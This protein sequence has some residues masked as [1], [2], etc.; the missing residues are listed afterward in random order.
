LKT[1][2]VRKSNRTIK[3]ISVYLLLIFIVSSIIS[4][5]Q[6]HR[7][8]VN[9][10]EICVFAKQF[11]TDGY[12]IKIGKKLDCSGYTRYVYKAFGIKIPRSAGQQYKHFVVTINN[13]LKPGDLVFFSSEKKTIGH[14]GIYLG[15]NNF[16]HSPGKNKEVVIDNLTKTYWKSRFKG[17]GRLKESSN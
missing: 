6:Q 12:L 2:E 17:S 8:S 13:D 15:K 14:V 4:Y 16:I 1:D 9:P 5:R 7:V 11:L 10:D 3:I